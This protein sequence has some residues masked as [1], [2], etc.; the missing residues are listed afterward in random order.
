LCQQSRASHPKLYIEIGHQQLARAA[1]SLCPHGIQLCL[2]LSL[3]LSSFPG[4]V[5]LC[6][7]KAMSRGDD[8]PCGM[9]LTHNWWQQKVNS[10]GISRR[11]VMHTTHC[12][13]N[14][15]ECHGLQNAAT[16]GNQCMQHGLTRLRV[17]R[18]SELLTMTDWPMSTWPVKAIAFTM[19]SCATPQ[20]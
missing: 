9:M 20:T 8:L 7:Q 14:A 17:L 12:F 13:D 11:T 19:S 2:R 3:L 6:L 5:F 15:E 18:T 16:I 10:I 1:A 4:Q